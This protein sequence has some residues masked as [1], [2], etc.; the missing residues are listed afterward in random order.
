MTGQNR[1]LLLIAYRAASHKRADE[2]FWIPFKTFAADGG[3][4]PNSGGTPFRQPC[5][6]YPFAR[7]KGAAGTFQRGMF[8]SFTST[9]KPVSLKLHR[10]SLLLHT[11]PQ[12]SRGTLQAWINSRNQTTIASRSKHRQLV[13]LHPTSENR[14]LFET[15][16]WMRRLL[17]PCPASTL[18]VFRFI[19][20][21]FSASARVRSLG[22]HK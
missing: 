12:K 21:R 19:S 13:L 22:S 10:Y 5:P 9:R 11:R 3:A 18:Q 14:D 7:A 6:A 2:R 20:V 1:S 15:G 17:I 8:P 4:R 16:L